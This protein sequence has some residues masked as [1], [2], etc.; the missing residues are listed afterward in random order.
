MVGDDPPL[1]DEWRVLMDIIAL[2][3]RGRKRILA[4]SR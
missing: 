1:R 3:E 4:I 2:A